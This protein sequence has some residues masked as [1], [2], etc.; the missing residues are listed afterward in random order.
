MSGTQRTPTLATAVLVLLAACSGG[1]PST[2][3]G[4]SPKAAG[5]TSSP[6]AV[7]YSACLRSHGVP[8]F[9]DP[10][11]SGQLPKGDAQRF[12]VSGSQ[13]QTARQVCQH[14]LPDNGGA[15]NTD[16]IQQ[17]MMADA[18]PPALVRQV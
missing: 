11:S 9:P 1:A 16:S 12:G 4:G 18:C 17:C 3:S 15:I 2:G 7:A 6:S 14:L 5:A 13:L 10:D 8:N